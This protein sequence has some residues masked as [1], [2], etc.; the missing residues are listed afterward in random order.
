MARGPLHDG[1][2]FCERFAQHGWTHTSVTHKRKPGQKLAYTLRRW[3]TT[4]DGTKHDCL[5][6]TQ[7]IDGFWASL[8]REVGRTGVQTGDEDST[9]RERLSS[10]VRVFQWHWWHL[11][12]DRYPLFCELVRAERAKGGSNAEQ[13]EESKQGEALVGEDDHEGCSESGEGNKEV[14]EDELLAKLVAAH[15]GEVEI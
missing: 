10:L 11:H 13:Q 1:E 5:C 9:T 2:S 12:T 3:I 14:S 15:L 8:R 7:I 4:K 6:G